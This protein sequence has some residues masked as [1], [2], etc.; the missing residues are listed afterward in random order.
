MG[1]GG[2]SWGKS[3]GRKLVK[4]EKD[5]RFNGHIQSL[6][7]TRLEMGFIKIVI[8]LVLERLPKWDH[9]GSEDHPENLRCFELSV[10]D[11]LC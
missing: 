9:K 11:V 7:K 4:Q 10:V 2:L 8:S 5:G 6:V 1:R 3:V